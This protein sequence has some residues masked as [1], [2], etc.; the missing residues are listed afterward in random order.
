MH[1]PRT[2]YVYV[3]KDPA[4][5]VRY[6]GITSNVKRRYTEHLKDTSDT[7][8][9]RWVRSL[10]RSGIKPT[11]EVITSVDSVEK[12]ISLEAHYIRLYEDVLHCK[13]T[14]SDRTGTGRIAFGH[15]PWN[16]GKELH[17]LRGKNSPHYGKTLP[18]D[19]R[20]KVSA[21]LMGNIPSNRCRVHKI[22]IATGAV[23]E[24][25]ESMAAA[26]KA[27]KVSPGNICGVCDNVCSQAAGFGWKRA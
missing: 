24:T 10:K 2:M 5:Q 17:H 14:N 4:E 27:N 19:V 20:D 18:Q 9:A 6:V 8:K 7:Y 3:L 13:L 16:K 12:A 23:I 22:D 21:S 1:E 26:A 25:Y 15:T 11:M